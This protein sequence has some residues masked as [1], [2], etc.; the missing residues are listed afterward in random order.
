MRCFF[1]KQA[2]ISCGFIAKRLRMTRIIFFKQE[3]VVISYGFIAKRFR[4]RRIMHVI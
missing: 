2:V 3:H 4:M 1:N